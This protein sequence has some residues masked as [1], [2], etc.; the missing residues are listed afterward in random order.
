M[1]ARCQRQGSF[2]FGSVRLARLGCA[3]DNRRKQGYRGRD[4]AKLRLYVA[5]VASSASAALATSRT[6]PTRIMRGGA[7]R[8]R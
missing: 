4:A 5:G 1:P 7:L 8:S 3:L 2:D 6:K